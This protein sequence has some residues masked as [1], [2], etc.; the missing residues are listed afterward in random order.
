MIITADVLSELYPLLNASSADDLL[1]WTLPEIAVSGAK[2]AADLSRSGCYA[3]MVPHDVQA[4]SATYAIID[5]DVTRVLGVWLDGNQ[6][7]PLTVAEAEALSSTWRTETGTVTHYLLDGYGL[8]IL[9]LYKTPTAAGTLQLLL[10]R[11]PPYAA[12]AFP[13]CDSIRDYLKYSILAECRR[14]EGD[15]EAPEVATAAQQRA[16]LLMSVYL[17]LWGQDV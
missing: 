10:I 5:A 1:F 2:A 11:V 12:G 16:D 14:R 13:A 6:L 4:G 3:S 9:A 7:R 15:G 17:E 8:R